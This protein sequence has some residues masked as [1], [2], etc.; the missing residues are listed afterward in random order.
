MFLGGFQLKFDMPGVL[1]EL[2]FIWSGNLEIIIYQGTINWFWTLFDLLLPKFLIVVGLYSKWDIYCFHFNFGLGLH[3][4]FRGLVS[5][6]EWDCIEPNT[7]NLIFKPKKQKKC[8]NIYPIVITLF[9]PFTTHKET[10]F[11]NS[12]RFSSFFLRIGHDLRTRRWIETEFPFHFWSSIRIL[13]VYSY[14]KHTLYVL[15]TLVMYVH[16]YLNNK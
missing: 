5:I 12:G 1:F 9:P 14:T 13:S 6:S 11:D 7:V 10:D 4:G 8:E 15:Q 16:M 3:Y 2:L